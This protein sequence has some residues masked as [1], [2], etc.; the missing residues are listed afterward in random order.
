VQR[1]A[2]TPEGSRRALQY[3]KIAHALRRLLALS[4]QQ[5]AIRLFLGNFRDERDQPS[6]AQLRNEPAD[7]RDRVTLVS[8]L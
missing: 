3:P 8:L 1:S 2:L 5:D 4:R 7:R 6:D